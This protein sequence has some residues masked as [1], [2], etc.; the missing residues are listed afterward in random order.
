MATPTELRHYLSH[1]FQLGK[2]LIINGTPHSIT[3]TLNTDRPSP[4]FET[5]WQQAL[6]QPHL[7]HLEGSDKT[8]SELLTGNWDIIECARCDMPIPLK[9]AGITD[10]ACVCDDMTTWPNSDT[11]APHNPINTNDR[12][13]QLRHHLTPTT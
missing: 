8:I 10:N 2:R 11:L 3:P 12:L 13:L 4:E 5:I 9:K 7:A 1:W 6:A